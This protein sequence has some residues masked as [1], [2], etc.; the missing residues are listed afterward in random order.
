MPTRT[1]EPLTK[2]PLLFAA[3]IAV[4][5]LACRGGCS[6]GKGTP[7]MSCGRGKHG[8]GGTGIRK[9]TT[10]ARSALRICGELRAAGI[11]KMCNIAANPPGAS[12]GVDFELSSSGA[13]AWVI[14]YPTRTTYQHE[15]D[16]RRKTS[17]VTAIGLPEQRVLIELPTAT[18]PSVATKIR[19]TLKSYRLD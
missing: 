8:G 12:D 15:L 2:R 10:T 16:A 13:T 14:R 7:G 6:C 4:A 17:G 9:T 5:L 1:T 3:A 19:S 18:P 11:A